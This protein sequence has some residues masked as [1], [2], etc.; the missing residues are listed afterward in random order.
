[1]ILEEPETLEFLYRLLEEPY[2]SE[3]LSHLAYLYVINGNPGRGVEIAEEVGGD[4][5]YENL[6]FGF[7]MI[8]DYERALEFGRKIKNRWL[9]GG[10]LL[11]AYLQRRELKE[12]ILQSAPE[13]VRVCIEERE[14][15]EGL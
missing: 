7:I 8:E 9:K 14:K 4:T 13:H 5:A 11:M 2:R 10:V 12:A 3:A 1:M 6:A 15:G